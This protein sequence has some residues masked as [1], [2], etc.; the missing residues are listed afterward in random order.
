MSEL[1]FNRKIL[2]LN[3]ARALK[4]WEKYNFIH[5]EVGQRIFENVTFTN[6]KFDNILE[7]SALDQSLK[8]NIKD[9]FQNSNYISSSFCL[10]PNSDLMLDDENLPFK[11]ASFDLII[12]NLNLHFINQIESFLLQVRNLLKEDGIFI[13]SFFGE[14]NLSE[15][16]LAIYEAENE[17]YGAV[18]PRMPPTI[19]VK[20]AANL[21]QK[22]GFKNPIS[23][24]QKI[25]V[26]YSNP[27]NL[28]KDLKYMGQG[29]I[30]NKKTRK[31]AKKE[32]IDKILQKYQTH[33]ANEDGSVKATFEIVTV[34][35]WK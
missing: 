2:R 5:Q 1:L 35:G 13:A 32:L 6:R 18:S 14:E 34:T 29:N 15:L 17:V 25:E 7:I 10:N 19:D 26:D 28:L 33:H 4:T 22:A 21:L 23:D 24:F 27:E 8:N 16:A 20:T 11:P 31:F 9:N 12:S 30:L 3:Q